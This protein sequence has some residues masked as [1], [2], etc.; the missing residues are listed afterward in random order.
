MV[1]PGARHRYCR[2]A[3]YPAKKRLAG[4][5]LAILIPPEIEK[6]VTDNCY[7]YVEDSSNASVKYAR[8]MLRHEVIPML[9]K[10]NP[11]LEKTFENNLQHFRDLKLC[12]NYALPN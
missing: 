2:S 7:P 1:K 6:L 9:K 8:N 11:G 5:A 10:L 3:W 4:K 12:L